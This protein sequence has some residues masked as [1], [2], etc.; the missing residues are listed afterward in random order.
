[1]YRAVTIFRTSSAHLPQNSA[2][3]TNLK[4]NLNSLTTGLWA[5]T[6]SAIMCADSSSAIRPNSPASVETNKTNQDA[7]LLYRGPPTLLAVFD[8]SSVCQKRPAIVS[9]ETY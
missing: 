8:G 2:P 4:T 9:K 6:S 5:D 3:L 7:N 1:M